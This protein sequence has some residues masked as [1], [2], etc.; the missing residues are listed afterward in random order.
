LKSAAATAAASAIPGVF[1]PAIAQAAAKV[2]V[3]GGGPGGA[4]A[5]KYIAKDAAGK[6]AVTLVEPFDTFTTCFHSNLYVGG[7][8]KLSEITHNYKKLVAAGIT[9]AKSRAMS[10]DRAKKTVKLADGKTLAYDRLVV[11]P[12][13]DLKFASVAGYSEDA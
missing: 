3:I 5:A 9:H 12:G 11:S 2:V 8:K 6:I 7:Y 10:I 1:A 4:T 13:I